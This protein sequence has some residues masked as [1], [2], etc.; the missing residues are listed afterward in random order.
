MCMACRNGHTEIVD[1]LVKAGANI[2]LAATE[3]FTCYDTLM[4][5]DPDLP[6]HVFFMNTIL[7]VGVNISHI[8]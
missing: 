2:H 5:C 6:C 4:L 3:V 1:L 8:E 7:R